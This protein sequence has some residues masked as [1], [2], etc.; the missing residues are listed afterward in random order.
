MPLRKPRVSLKCEV[1]GASFELLPCQ[2]GRGRGR[3]CS[4]PCREESYRRGSQMHCDLCDGVFYK[5]KAEQDSARSFCSAECYADWRAA[6]MK[7][8]TYPRDGN[9]NRHRVVA[10]QWLG[11]PLAPGE[12]VHHIDEDKHNADPSNLAVFPTQAM[13]A[14]CHKGGVSAADLDRYRLVNLPKRE[15]VVGAEASAEEPAA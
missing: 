1:C 15:P 14:L 7:P 2:L 3:Y 6:Q 9:R 10:E 5:Q 13:H 4:K 12:V 11:R 8:D